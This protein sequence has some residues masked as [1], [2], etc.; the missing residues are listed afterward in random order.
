MVASAGIPVM[1]WEW[2]AGAAV[3]AAGDSAAAAP[4]AG[5]GRGAEA[6][7]TTRKTKRNAARPRVAWAITVGRLTVGN[8]MGSGN[9]RKEAVGRRFPAMPPAKRRRWRIWVVR[10]RLGLQRIRKTGARKLELAHERS[11]T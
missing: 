5:S 9:I 2:S 6:Q 1:W 3:P 8:R 4:G 10:A 7:P 11:G